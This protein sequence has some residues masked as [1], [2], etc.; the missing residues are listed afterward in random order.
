ML[1]VTDAYVITATFFIYAGAEAVPVPAR[2]RAALDPDH[3]RQRPLADRSRDRV[4]G[5]VRGPPPQ[6]PP[7]HIGVLEMLHDYTNTTV[8]SVRTA[9]TDAL[10]EADALIEQA[11]AS[12]DA[13]SFEATMRPLDLAGAAAM[14]G[15]ARAHSWPTSTPTPPS[16]TPARRPRRRSRSGTWDSPSART[17]TARCAPSPTRRRRPRSRASRSAS[18]SS[19]CATSAAPATSSR[20]RTRPSS[21]RCASAWSSWRWRSPATSTTTRKGSRSRRERPGRPART[22]TSI[23]SA[24]ATSQG[25]IKVSVKGPERVPFMAQAHN[26]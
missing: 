18:S 4:R 8:E 10:A 15:Y 25:P 24:P 13:P 3:R 2:R 21:R 5:Q 6:A 14:R 7:R 17:C 26:R 19:G 22:T 11:V 16:A 1:A 9:V 23:G 12:A 20:R